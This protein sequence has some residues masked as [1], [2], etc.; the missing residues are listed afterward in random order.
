MSYLRN[1]LPVGGQ[2]L[3][4]TA[5]LFSVQTPT[6]Q[7]RQMT[8]DSSPKP[9]GLVASLTMSSKL[10][11]ALFPGMQIFNRA[12]FKHRHKSEACRCGKDTLGAFVFLP[13]GTPGF[14]C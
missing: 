14:L 7:R 11:K 2:T 5:V 4:L 13:V 6:V 12:H 1:F 8:Q 9:R 3:T 10:P